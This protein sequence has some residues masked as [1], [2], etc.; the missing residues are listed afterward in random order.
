MIITLIINLNKI[1][2]ITLYCNHNLK[3]QKLNKT[4]KLIKTFN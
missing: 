2:M 4:T 1:K 3:L